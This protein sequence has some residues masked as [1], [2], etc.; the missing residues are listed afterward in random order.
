MIGSRGV[1]RLIRH[2]TGTLNPMIAPQAKATKAIN[3]TS[4][5]A[6]WSQASRSSEFS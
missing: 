1:T 2:A 5:C 3:G 6:I 4:C